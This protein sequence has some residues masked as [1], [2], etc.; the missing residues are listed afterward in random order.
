MCEDWLQDVWSSCT[1][2]NID[3]DTLRTTMGH[4]TDKTKL[5]FSDHKQVLGQY[6]YGRMTGIQKRMSVL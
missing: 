3:D 1:L 4:E 2:V 6:L 5:F